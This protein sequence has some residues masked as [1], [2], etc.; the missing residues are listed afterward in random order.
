[1][2]LAIPFENCARH[3]LK[4]LP[5]CP[6]SLAPCWATSRASET[7]T[8]D[9]TVDSSGSQTSD[10]AVDSFSWFAQFPCF[11]PQIGRH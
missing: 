2:E 11:P 8:V 5:V 9:C 7:Q 3:L 6:S 1:M 4:D 10:C